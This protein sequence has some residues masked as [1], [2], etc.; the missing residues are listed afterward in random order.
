MDRNKHQAFW[1]GFWSGLGASVEA[2]DVHRRRPRHGR[3]SD[4]DAMHGD[5]V[6]VGNDIRIAYARVSEPKTD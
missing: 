6:R 3:L 1:L 4:A 5:W 2:L